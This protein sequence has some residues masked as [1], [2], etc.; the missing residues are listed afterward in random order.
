MIDSSRFALAGLAAGLVFTLAACILGIAS[1]LYYP[2]AG[3]INA[4]EGADCVDLTGG[5]AGDWQAR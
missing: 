4:T 5:L 3:I 2:Q 1:A